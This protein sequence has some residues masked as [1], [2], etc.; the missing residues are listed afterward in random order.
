[1]FHSAA[2]SIAFFADGQGLADPRSV[3]P[4]Y[5]SRVLTRR[6]QSFPP[7]WLYNTGEP[8]QRRIDEATSAVLIRV[9]GHMGMDI[10]TIGDGWQTEYGD[11]RENLKNFP[12]GLARIRALLEEQKMGLGLWVPLAAISTQAPDYKQ[13][14]RVAL[15]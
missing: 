6:G 14:P 9:A 13:P 1:M 5:A 2:S 3:A 15:P 8:F 12:G 4:P 10:F 7:A 11:N